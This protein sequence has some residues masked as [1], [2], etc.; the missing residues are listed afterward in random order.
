MIIEINRTGKKIVLNK[1]KGKN[2]GSVNTLLAEYGYN[3]INVLNYDNHNNI[4]WEGIEF[5]RLF[6]KDNIIYR[7]NHWTGEAYPWD[8][9]EIEEIGIERA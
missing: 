9:A 8:G 2:Y 5:N 7:F 1:Q 6:K 3:S 4:K